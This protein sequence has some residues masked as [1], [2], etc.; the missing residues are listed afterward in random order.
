[1]NKVLS[2]AAMLMLAAGP[3]VAHVTLETAAAAVG[4]AYK[5]VLRVPHGC[6]GKATDAVRVRIPEGFVAVK[7]M[8]KPGWTIEKVVA[9][10]AAEYKL[11]GR[12]VIEGVTEIA[13][14]GGSLADDE[15]DEFVF[16][17]TLDASMEGG[18]TIYFPVIQSCGQ[19]VAHWIEVP[20]EGQDAHELEFPAPALELTHGEHAGH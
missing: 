15:Y 17:G 7:P 10:Y 4:T 2:L 16:R 14:S 9:P 6:D 12:K 5:A 8:P 18:K 20:A 11:H 19:D 3:A 1:M 13:W